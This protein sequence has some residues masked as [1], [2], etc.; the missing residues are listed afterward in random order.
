MTT[1]HREPNGG[2]SKGKCL[3]K[4][5]GRRQ[6]EQVEEKQRNLWVSAFGISSDVQKQK[7]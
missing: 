6:R 2:N 5:I 7:V 4:Q 3:T 1:Y